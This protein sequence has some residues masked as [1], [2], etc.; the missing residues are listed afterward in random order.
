MAITG[1]IPAT[2]IQDRRHRLVGHTQC[3]GGLRN[4]DSQRLQTQLAQ[5][6]TWMRGIMHSRF[7]TSVIV[8][9]VN[10]YRFLPTKS[11]CD[12]PVPTYSNGPVSSTLP[13]QL[14]KYEPR[15]AN[16]VWSRRCIESAKDQSK[17]RR[18]LCLNTCL[19]SGAA[20][21]LEPIVP[22]TCDYTN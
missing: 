16:A 22:R 11:K 17:A 10:L 4:T 15:Q 18:V 2:P 3:R 8:L 19:A 13:T 21:V 12:P 1:L 5:N 7:V 14:L 6:L 20:E 9:I